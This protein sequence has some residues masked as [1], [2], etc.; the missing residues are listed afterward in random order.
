MLRPLP[1]RAPEELVWLRDPS[2]SYPVFEQIRD[3]GHMLRGLFAWEQRTLHAAWTSES[4]PTS[5]LLVTGAFHDTLGLPPAAGRLLN[6][7]DVGNTPA[8]AQAVAV[9]SYTAW[10][11]RFGGD[12][13]AVGRTLRVEGQPFTIVGVT[14]PGFFG[15]AVGMSPDVTIPVTMLPRLRSDE[16]DSL[17]QANQFWLNIMGRVRP[18]M[19]IA[20]ADAAFQP[21][22]TQALA[23]TLSPEWS[24]RWRARW[25]TFT[26]GLEPGAAGYSPVR[27]QFQDALWLLFGLV[28]LV[29]V[30]ACATVA[31]LL[32]AA[33]AGRR[34]ELALRL[35]IGAGRGR[36]VQQ[37]F[38][39]GLLLASMGGALGFLFSAWAADLLVQLLST[40]YDPV[41]MALGVDGRV[42]A[43][44][45]GAI[46]VAAIA[47][48]IAPI[49]RAVRIDPGPV[50]KAGTRQAGADR[51]PAGIARALVA[52]QVALSMVLL[53]GSALFVRNLTGLL[54]KDTGF[55]RDGLLVVNVDVLSPVSAH[56]AAG[57]RAPD[58][59]VWYGELL[60]RLQETPGVRSASLSR[61]PPISNEL[62]YWFDFFTVEGQT[63][64][65]NRAHDAQWADVPQRRVSRLFRDDG[66]AVHRRTRLLAERRRG[67]SPGR[68]DQRVDGC[69]VFRS[70]E[71]RW[72]AS[73]DGGGR[74][75]PQRRG[76]RRRPRLGLPPSPGRAAPRRLCALHAGTRH[77]EGGQPLCRG[78][79]GRRGIDR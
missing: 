50:L 73:D 33:A 13:A 51:R 29:L 27:R 63:G 17:V 30:V 2:F 44:T 65:R 18:G 12:P 55:D 36:L 56:A 78:A 26:S 59:T 6:Q 72:T 28:A 41:T 52:A 24:P 1:V 58:L 16:R 4:E 66:H 60:R 22:W 79:H 10:Q 69:R 42:L 54:T 48:T 9:L 38:V 7:A 25:V 46:G 74:R 64:G 61:K 62:G 47:F 45:A 19:S 3:R 11:R 43:F 23:A 8:E 32:L 35:A 77:P 67:A 39:E 75:D 68:R 71:S 76:D 37:L 40:S 31:N 5:M 70:G 20:Q 57:D 14:P 21:V 34:R 53:V 49:V 15:V